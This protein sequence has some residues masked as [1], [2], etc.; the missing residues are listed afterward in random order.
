MVS[1]LTNR[2]F[3]GFKNVCDC[4][5]KSNKLATEAEE[6]LAATLAEEKETDNL[7]TEIAMTE[8]NTGAAV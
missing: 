2:S 8:A 5:S 3:Q 1:I 4:Q 7:L 6:L